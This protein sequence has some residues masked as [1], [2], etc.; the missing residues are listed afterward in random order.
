MTRI[1][2]LIRDRV[3]GISVP[4]IS[5]IKPLI[6]TFI[7]C[8]ILIF[9]C[10]YGT[11]QET[12][13][14]AYGGRIM[15]EVT[16]AAG[17]RATGYFHV[18]RSPNGQW[19]LVTPEGN[20]FFSIGACVIGHVGS[21]APALGYAP[22]ERNVMEKYGT[23]EA[24]TET[25]TERLAQ[26][27]FNTRGAWSGDE[28][29]LPYFAI[30]Y[31]APEQ[32]GTGV[33]PDF[34]SP[35]FTAQAEEIAREHVHPNDKL[36]IGYFMDNEMQ[37][38]TDWRRGPALFDHYMSFDPDAKGKHALMALLMMRYVTVVALA[39]VWQPPLPDWDALLDVD[40]LTPVP[41][42]EQQA[43]D[44]REAFTYMAARQ[45]FNVA[46]GAL[47]RH[48]PNHLIAGNRFISWTTPA[49][50]ILAA[51]EFFDIVSVNHYEIA[52]LGRQLLDGKPESVRTP[53]GDDPGLAAFHR[54][55]A[56]PLMI[57]EFGFRAMDSGLPNTFPPPSVVQPTVP[58]Q[59][60]RAKKYR[61]YT[62][63]W[64]GLPWFVGYHWFRYMDEPKEGR[65]D[66]ENGNYGLVNIEDEP[67]EEFVS[68]V[69]TAND[70]AWGLH[71]AAAADDPLARAVG[72]VPREVKVVRGT[73]PCKKICD[74]TSEHPLIAQGQ[75]PV[76]TPEPD[77]VAHAQHLARTMACASY[78]QAAAVSVTVDASSTPV[79]VIYGYEIKKG[80]FVT[81]KIRYE[82]SVPG[83]I[84]TLRQAAAQDI[85]FIGT[86]AAG[87]VFAISVSSE[88]DQETFTL[89]LWP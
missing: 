56:R 79:K 36:L 22:Y 49:P 18:A 85:P 37:W 67:Y 41:G 47:R 39:K 72:M 70:A 2:F 87:L 51:G 58:T 9:A 13:T 59:K 3:P 77:D 62:S 23:V 74:A 71:A 50:V 24:W 33:M 75:E 46:V 80:E 38:D 19:W 4:G 16:S 69:A 40:K 25:A 54:L 29:A 81:L 55:A 7:L 83:L 12:A 84:E 64:S 1:C 65:F 76:L 43:L 11:A 28:T 82:N 63:L 17:L 66:G 78:K 57:T 10:V 68:E 35:E 32:W 21:E 14:D 6:T 60:A 61:K 15:P 88:N 53:G 5:G 89:K 31:F 44:D 52:E 48:D 86:G 34:F 73:C 45:Y 30:V 26:W 20:P 42:A 27:G 8:T